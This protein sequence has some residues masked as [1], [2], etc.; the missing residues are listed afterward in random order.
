MKNIAGTEP[1]ETKS[2]ATPSAPF[3]RSVASC[4]LG[5]T[6]AHEPQNSPSVTKPASVDD[7]RGITSQLEDEHRLPG[8]G[9]SVFAET[10]AELLG[11]AQRRL[12]LGPDVR[13][14]VVGA[15]AVPRVRDCRAHRLRREPAP[16]EPP[17][18]P[19][20][21]FHF[22]GRDAGHA[23]PCVVNL[24]EARERVSVKEPPLAEPVLPPVRG[25]LRRVE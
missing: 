13:D 20:P 12:V 17:D 7:L 18:D 4:T 14:E 21:R 8:P 11:D 19:P 16:A 1:S 2:N 5:S 15:R 6:D 23:R 10:E 22:V 3:E 9:Q 25:R 24:G